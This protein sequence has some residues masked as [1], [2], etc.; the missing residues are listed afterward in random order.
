MTLSV[1]RADRTVNR[2]VLGRIDHA[3]LSVLRLI[4]SVNLGGFGRIEP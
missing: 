1:R 4:E 3:Y 2:G